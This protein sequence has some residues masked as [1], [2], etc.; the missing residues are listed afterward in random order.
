MNEK[1]DIRSFVGIWRRIHI[2]VL[3]AIVFMAVAFNA[4]AEGS[5]QYT[6]PQKESKVM[7]RAAL[8]TSAPRVDLPPIDLIRPAKTEI[9]VFA[10]G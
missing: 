7:N 10:M 2:I 8:N 6:V 4:H 1:T 3:F 5:T 9:A